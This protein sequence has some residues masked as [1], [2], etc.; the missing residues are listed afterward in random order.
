MI[1][2]PGRWA[3]PY[4]EAGAYNVTFHAEATDD[5]RPSRVT[6]APPGPK[7]GLAI[8]PGTRSTPTWRSC[9]TWTRCWS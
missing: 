9:A 1:D 5:P 8:K 6:S 2:D 3:P 4:A 7:T